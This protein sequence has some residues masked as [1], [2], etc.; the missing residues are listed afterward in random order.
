LWLYLHLFEYLF[1]VAFKLLFSRSVVV[2]DRF[3]LDV[4]IDVLYDT[5]IN[6]VK[7][8]AGKFFLLYFHRLLLRGTIRG[9]VM[10]VDVA[11]VFRRRNDIPCRSYIVFRIPVYLALAKFFGVP[12]VD[13]RGDIAQNFKRVLEYLGL[14]YG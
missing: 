3:M 10:H 7:T 2:A 4:F 13:G 9:V 5:H 14:E 11:T 6:A 1:Y 8:F 12:I